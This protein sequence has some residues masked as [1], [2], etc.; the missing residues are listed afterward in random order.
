MQTK[1]FDFFDAARNR[2]VP[3]IVYFPNNSPNNTPTVI[4]NHGYT[5]PEQFTKIDEGT[6]KLPHKNHTYLAKFFTKKGYAFICTQHDLRSDVDGLGTIDPK[7]ATVVTRKH[8]WERGVLNLLFVIEE[9][10]K[11]N[12]DLNLDRFI[13]GGHSNGGDIAKYFANH[14]PHLISH[15][16]ICDGRRCPISPCVNLRILMFE[17]NDTSTDIGVIPDQGTEENLKRMNL[18]WV[19]VKPLNALHVGYSDDGPKEL[20]DKVTKTI[21]WFLENFF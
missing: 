11:Q 4:Y 1:E 5:D 20:H 19:V 17:A 16:I 12:L 9:L 7:S 3:V 2:P 21:D 15:L 18:E 10:K 14:N 13:I 8:L 6:Q